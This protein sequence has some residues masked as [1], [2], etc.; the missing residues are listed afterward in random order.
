MSDTQEISKPV[1]NDSVI[2]NDGRS[3]APLAASTGT[4]ETELLTSIPRSLSYYSWKRLKRNK[5]AMGGLIVTFIL[6]I[7]A[8]FASVIAP[9]DPNLQVLEYSAKPSGFRGNVILQKS[10]IAG[11]DADPIAIKSYQIVGDHIK[12][13]T[14]DDAAETLPLSSLAGSNESEWHKESV[15]YLG[16]DHFG[17]DLLSRLMYGARVSLS[18]AFFSEVLSLLIGVVLGA[19]AGFYRG[20]IDELSMWMTNVVWSIPSA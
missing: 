1:E 19:L 16:T 17:R 3:G 7:V 13:V 18:V 9:F 8:A 15:Y 11:N 6:I 5:L 4:S 12:L 20:W 10:H 2:A 14:I